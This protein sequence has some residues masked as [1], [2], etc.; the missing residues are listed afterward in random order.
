MT[1]E[2]KG[3]IGGEGAAFF[4][5]TDQPSADSLAE[6]IAVK[7]FYKPANVAANI[8]A[9]LQ[10]QSLEID[11]IDLV[12]TGKNGDLRNDETYSQL[13][14]SLFKN[15]SLANYKHLCGEYPTSSSFALWLAAKLVKKS[16]VPDIII[17]KIVKDS[18]PKRVLIYNHYQNK[19]HS[20]MLVSAI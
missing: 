12:L 5:L 11:D 18:S 13:S 6:L 1:T 16:V 8:T 4:L 15:M 14:T 3:T 9:F 20:L 7:T 2:S 17:E 10:E 19:Y